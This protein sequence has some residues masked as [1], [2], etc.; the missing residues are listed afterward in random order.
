MDHFWERLKVQPPAPA[1]RKACGPARGRHR[2]SSA[3][4]DPEVGTG[5]NLTTYLDERPQ[6]L[7]RT[8]AVAAVTALFL[9]GC[10]SDTGS[11]VDVVDSPDPTT[12]TAAPEA[13]ALGDTVNVGG[14]T[15]S[16]IEIITEGCEF[17]TSPTRDAVKFQLLATVENGTS[18]EILQVLWPTDITFIDP[19]GMSVK[20]M[21]IVSGEPSCANDHPREFINMTPGEKRRAAVTV[22]APVGAEEMIYSTSLIEGA[23]PV[24]WDI[25]DEVSGL[26]ASPS[27][28]EVTATQAATAA[29]AT[30]AVS[31]AP[32]VPAAPSAPPVIGFTEA[33]GHG[34]PTPMNKTISSCGDPMLH[35]PGTTFFTDGSSGWTQE[36]ANQMG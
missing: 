34:S 16:D 4:A 35:Q 13:H 12:S 8:V 7:R 26:A 18:D 10:S 2:A 5:G 28:P 22:E 11:E 33:P 24:R 1:G 3:G 29:P 20:P 36:C 21:D 31:A 23:S 19:D 32:S 27:E 25:A 17:S 30:P 6:M 9:A 15:I 14:V